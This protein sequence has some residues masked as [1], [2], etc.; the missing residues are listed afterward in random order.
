VYRF[1]PYLVLSLTLGFGCSDASSGPDDPAA[2]K[3]D[4]SDDAPADA[5]SS[6][7][8]G[9]DGGPIDGGQA[10][11][12]DKITFDQA[13]GCFNDGSIEFCLPDGDDAAREYVRKVAP[14]AICYPDHP[15]RGRAGCVPETHYLCMLPHGVGDCVEPWPAMS[16]QAWAR[17]CDLAAH[18]AIER[19][20]P[21]WFE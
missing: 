19:I 6:D 10:C 16:D 3:A 20:V 14:T 4:Y 12:S 5:G 15:S 13:H 18:D 9:T 8:G 1:L 11:R 7:G 17:T 2:G 21:T